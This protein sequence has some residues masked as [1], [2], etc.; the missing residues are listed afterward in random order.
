MLDFILIFAI[1]YKGIKFKVF[2][3]KGNFKYDFHGID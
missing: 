3:D 1:F 2:G